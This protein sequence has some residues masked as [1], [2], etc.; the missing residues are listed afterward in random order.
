MAYLKRFLDA[1]LARLHFLSIPSGNVVMRP[2]SKRYAGL[3]GEGCG[4]ADEP[5][6][7][8]APLVGGMDRGIEEEG[9]LPA[10]PGEVDESYQ[11]IVVERTNPPEAVRED[12]LPVGGLRAL[13]GGDAER[14]ECRVPDGWVSH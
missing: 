8:P 9:M 1:P 13:P 5:G 4:L 10:V 2:Q 14:V 12:G 7:D 11:G 3:K 6:T